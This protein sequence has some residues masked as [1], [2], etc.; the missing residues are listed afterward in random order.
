M[1]RKD[2]VK[3]PNKVLRRRSQRVGVITDE[4]RNLAQAMMDATLDWEDHRQNEVGVALAAVQVGQPVRIVVVRADLKDK[5][6]RDFKV[7]INPEIV[8]K[9]GEIINA[10]EGCLSVADVYGMVP[11]YQKVK[12]K[13][14][15]S[16]GRAVR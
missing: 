14:L 6:N 7:F 5:D 2:I 16:E 8:K 15:N 13:A 10:P 1:T 9:E 11:R 3:L 12:V 4:V